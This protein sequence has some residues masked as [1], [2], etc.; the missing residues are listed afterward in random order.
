MGKFIRLKKGFT[1][2]LAGKAASKVVEIEQPD[3]FVIKPTDFHGTYMPKPVVKEGDTV[4]AGSP[5]FHDKRHESIIYSAPVSGEVVEIK[6]G[7]KRKLLEIKILADKKVEYETFKK[8]T[9]SEISNL[10]AA[11]LK[12]QLLASGVWPN[13]IERPFGVVADPGVTPKAIHISAFD[14]HPLAPDYTVLY[15][16]QD[17]Y[18]QVGV[19]I[20][21]KFTSGNVHINTHATS[22][23]S[24]LFS[25]VK[26]AEVNKFSGPH[27]VGCVGVQIHHLDPINKG[28]IVWT[29]APAGVIQIGKLF[30]N[31]IYDASK[32][33]ALTGSEVKSPQYYKTYTGASV[34]KFLQ[35]NLKQDHVRVISGNPLTGTSVGKEGHIGFF[36]QQISVL[37]EGDYAEFVG[38]ITPGERKL[39]FH[40]AIGLFSFLSPGK[41][42]VVDTNTH[43]EPRA[44]VQSG[45]FEQVVPMD[46]LPTH[47][48]KSILAEDIDEMEALGIYEVIEEDLA[49]CEFVDVSKHKVQEIL[50]E[51]LELVQQS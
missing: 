40:R 9:I 33:V 51:G 18:F 30:L 5:L 20:L 48:L 27:P 32:L 36:D 13:L 16:G 35:D 46:I 42:R 2:N 37:P 50:R 11:A 8:Y 29:I 4:K 1:I 25:Q 39:S 34:K 43:G 28:Q 31:G 22:E 44:F 26:G 45:I 14:T 12:E 49:L 19:D 10:S 38:W 7:E 3:T 21:K 15:K 24:T 17:Q 23:I 47:L 41:E 6:R